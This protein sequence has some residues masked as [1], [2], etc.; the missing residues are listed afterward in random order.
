MIKFI[1]LILKFSRS[2]FAAMEKDESLVV[3]RNDF[4]YSVAK[5]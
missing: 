4:P 2:S 1:I 5:P 3:N